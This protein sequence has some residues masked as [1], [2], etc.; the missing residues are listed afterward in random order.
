MLLFFLLV[1][2]IPLFFIRKKDDNTGIL[3]S[4]STTCIKGVLCLYI[5]LH[6]LGLDYKG[7]SDFALLICEHTGGIGVGVFFFLSAFGIIRAY[8]KKGNKYLSKLLL[9]NVPRLYL[10]SVCINMIIYFGFLQ[11][12][13]APTIGWLKIFNLEPFIDFKGL[14][15]H[16][17]YIV[18]IIFMYIVFSF[19]YYLFSKLK[20]DKKF[21]Y[22][23]IILAIIA[24]GLGDTIGGRYTRGID[25]FAIGCMY[26]TFYDKVNVFFK[27]YF[28][29]S[30]IILIMTYFI[31]LFFVEPLGGYSI[32][33]LLICLSQKITYNNKITH[34]LGKICLGVYLFLY[35]SSFIMQPFVHNQ[36][37]W[38][39]TNAILI[40]FLSIG[41][42][43]L[44]YFIT[45]LIRKYNEKKITQ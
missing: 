36:Y 39:I 18:S 22:A 27:K 14:N 26:A 33:L 40:L 12:T 29:P 34:F 21:I 41:L 10:I 38:V 19:V 11:G 44:E 25:C 32:S 15:P 20:T 30:L 42:Y 37:L 1:L 45:Y 8:Q 3:D 9:V 35:V 16:G 2:I 13:M 7:N 5:M 17:W 28:Y 4:Y 43:G 6:N 24:I 31:G 23:G